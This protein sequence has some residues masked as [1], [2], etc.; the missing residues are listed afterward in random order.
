M[1][2]ICILNWNCLD[3]LRVTLD[4]IKSELSVPFEVIVYDQSSTDGSREFLESHADHRLKPI[5]SQSNVGNCSSRN[6][7]IKA[8]KFKY[9]L[10]LDSDIVPISN[11]IKKMVEFMENNNRCAF[12]GYDFKSY[13]N[14]W[15]DVTK[16]EHSIA[17]KDIKTIGV[18]YRYKIALTQ[19]GLFRRDVL[20]ECP[21]PE[22]Y[23]FDR[24]GWGGEDDM[25]GQAI[26]ENPGVFGHGL[27]VRGRVYFHNKSSS[28]KQMGDDTFRSTYMKRYIYCKYFE[29]FL[30]PKQKISALKNQKLPDTALPCNHYHWDKDSNLGDVATKHLLDHEFPF[31]K[32]D[33]HE[34][35]RLLMFGGTIFDHIKSANRKF[36]A[37]FK[38]ILMFGVGV[39]KQSEVDN[40]LKGLRNDK[41]SFRIIPRGPKT[42]EVLLAAGVKCEKP[43][44]DVI[45][46][47]SSRPMAKHENQLPLKILSPYAQNSILAEP[48]FLAKVA[49]NK[50]SFQKL[51]M[52]DLEKFFQMMEISGKVH[53][54]QVHPFLMAALVGKPCCLY[55]S[56]WRTEDFSYFKNYKRD[57][58]ADEAALLRMEAQQNIKSFVNSFYSNLKFIYE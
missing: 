35:K 26:A 43:C 10:L 22:F 17:P 32:F 6:E 14:N 27:I 12:I 36:K 42:E 37:D 1:V 4:R 20:L 39:S 13:S 24:E 21:F 53:S 41:M 7:M 33:P 23:P 34:K 58:S 11:S 47:F 3:T 18:N 51:P 5:L 45:Q 31:F 38:K 49:D 52:L 46:L 57:M 48:S 40:G 25:V 29:N 15:E 9:V 55:S 50:K 8:A 30:G 16:F 2:S 28:I 54:P 44:G 19:Y 56:D